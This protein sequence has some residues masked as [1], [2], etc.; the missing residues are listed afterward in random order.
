MEVETP[1][2]GHW[3]CFIRGVNFIQK[4]VARLTIL[5]NHKIWPR[6][7]AITS[8]HFMFGNFQ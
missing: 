7:L 1:I 2:A 4:A 8:P 6:K 3:F 5:L